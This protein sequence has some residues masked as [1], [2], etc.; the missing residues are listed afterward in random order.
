[1]KKSV[2]ALYICLGILLV[3]LC[4]YFRESLETFFNDLGNAISEKCEENRDKVIRRQIERKLIEEEIRAERAVSPDISEMA[5]ESEPADGATKVIEDSDS[6]SDAIPAYAEGQ[7][8]LIEKLDGLIV[9]DE[10]GIR[11][12]VIAGL[13]ESGDPLVN[14]VEIPDESEGMHF[15]PDDTIVYANKK[16]DL[17]TDS[18]L[19]Y[20]A[21]AAVEWEQFI[22]V[23]VSGDCI[24]ELVDSG[25]N[26]M[27]SNGIFFGREREDMDVAE[28]ISMAKENVQLDVTNISQY[29][30]LPNGCEV[31]SLAIVLNYLGYDITK[32]ELSDNYLPKAP[33]GEADFYEEFV[34]EPR[35]DDSYGCYSDV[36]VNTANSF[37]MA[38]SSEYRAVNYSGSDFE[39]LLEKIK[40]G[41]PVIIWTAYHMNQEPYFTAEWIVDGEYLPWKANMH[42]MV[43]RGYNTENGTV[44]VAN[45]AGR[46]ESYDMKLFIK[47]YKQFYSQ[48]VV[49]E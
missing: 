14:Y 21:R 26:I 24:Y 31:T 47:R 3:L 4:V 19:T 40:E 46:Y 18:T 2:K 45:P 8:S 20:Q 32:E 35:A 13:A 16:A 42:C 30:S 27:Y 7:D 41:K 10:K 39:T 17:F 36:I 43:L 44:S 29:P 5:G 9:T 15:R 6:V 38:R 48:A 22:R 11:Y 12:Y 49:I 25:G 37:L 23:G 28:N 1:M 34:G 33:I